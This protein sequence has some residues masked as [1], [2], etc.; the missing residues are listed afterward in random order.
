MTNEEAILRLARN[1]DDKD[2]LIAVAENNFG[3]LKKSVENYFS[4]RATRK[5]A[6]LALLVHI[7]WHAK[8]FVQGDDADDW[9][10][11]CADSECRRLQNEAGRP[12]GGAELHAFWDA[13][14]PKRSET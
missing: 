3:I 10:V 12:A 2:G 6:F 4:G 13:Q 1:A 5:K 7:S 8:E 14:F 9:I 11:A